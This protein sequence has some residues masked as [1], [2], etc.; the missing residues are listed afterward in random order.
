MT[1]QPTTFE[2]AAE[3]QRLIHARID[4]GE[5]ISERE[6]RSHSLREGF[7]YG[8]VLEYGTGWYATN[9]ETGEVCEWNGRWT[10]DGDV[11]LCQDCF[12]DGT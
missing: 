5:N 3:R 12:E 1:D 6:F 7:T 11:L 8:P 4:A 2:E 10:D 9:I